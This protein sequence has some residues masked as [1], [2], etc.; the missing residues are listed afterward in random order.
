MSILSVIDHGAYF[1]SLPREYFL[2]EE[3]FEQELERI[4]RRQWLYAA[5]TSQ[6]PEAGDFVVREIVGESVVIVRDDGGEVRA[7]LNL[8]RHR[9]ARICDAAEGSV[10]RFTCPYHQWSYELDGRLRSAPSIADGD[11]IDYADWGLHT[12]HVDVWHG[13]IFVSL[14]DERPDPI[15][16]VL[17]AIP[18]RLERVEPER[19]KLAHT[20]TYDMHVNWKVLL[21]NYQECY[22][23][24]VAHPELSRIIDVHGQFEP[25]KPYT[26]KEVM[27]GAMDQRAGMQS[28]SLDGRRVCKKLLGEFGRGVEPPE[29][30]AAGFG[31]W[32]AFSAAGFVADYGVVQEMRPVAIDRV[33]F[34]THW[35]V[36]EDAVEGR[37][38]DVEQLIALWDVT[39]RQDWELCDRV[40]AGI[41]SRRFV[42]GPSSPTREQDLQ[43]ALMLYLARMEREA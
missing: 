34:V 8:C 6:L 18:T 22:H 14:A 33:D 39:N 10:K 25:R 42:P 3:I 16:D 21:E 35:F 27:A 20:I 4:W 32:P 43:A 1:T 2:S 28:L 29:S 38:Y 30:F 13:L 41:Q 11:G 12:V 24:L 40:Q 17:S 36:H 15:S 9:G 37:D 31:V 26:P 23:C 19:L 5:H 7:F